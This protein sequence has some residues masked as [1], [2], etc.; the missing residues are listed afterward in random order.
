MQSLMTV[1]TV[2]LAA[3]YELG[4]TNYGVLCIQQFKDSVRHAKPA[5]FA[6]A[7]L[8][9]HKYHVCFSVNTARQQLVS[10]CC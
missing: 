2:W 10:C 9:Q 8:C 4:M 5:E 7:L 6:A 1:M 3:Y